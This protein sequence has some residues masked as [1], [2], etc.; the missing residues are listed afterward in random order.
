ME[1]V[2][3]IRVHKETKEKMD[4]FKIHERE[5]YEDVLERLMRKAE[6]NDEFMKREKA[7]KSF[8]KR[9][10]DEHGKNVEDIIVYG[11]FARGEAG[12]ESDVDILIIWTG[13]L[14]KGREYAAELATEA[15]CDY[16][17]VISP[18]VVS[19]KNYREMRRAE[20][21]F[22]QNVEVEGIKLG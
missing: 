20:L 6:E 14:S 9:M 13:D 3:T 2:T 16:G 10:K 21:P 1:N 19:P 17:V 8:A 5:P 12:A 22:I 7:V 11:S 15:L 4:R 18:K